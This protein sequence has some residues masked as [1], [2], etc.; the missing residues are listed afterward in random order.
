MNSVACFSILVLTWPVEFFAWWSS[1]V[2]SKA[3]SRGQPGPAKVQLQLPRVLCLDLTLGAQ[4]LW[5]FFCSHFA[6]GQGA[7]RNTIYHPAN[8][9]TEL[10][11]PWFGRKPIYK[12][13][14]FQ[15]HVPDGTMVDTTRIS[16][17]STPRP[18][19]ARRPHQPRGEQCLPLWLLDHQAEIANLQGFFR[20]SEHS[21]F[22]SCS[23]CICLYN[24]WPGWFEEGSP[25]MGGLQWSM[26]V[27]SLHFGGSADDQTVQVFGWDL[28][29]FAT[30]DYE[31]CYPFSTREPWP[32]KGPRSFFLGALGFRKF[33]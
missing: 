13:R 21:C 30:T 5:V 18:F 20:P 12:C 27:V 26:H 11:N 23:F 8:R 25:R 22:D 29:L 3:T 14:V 6:W 19:W 10:G 24:T 16:N 28:V 2:L 32:I 9:D 17:R 4:W 15:V 33:L 1:C 31:Y 7:G